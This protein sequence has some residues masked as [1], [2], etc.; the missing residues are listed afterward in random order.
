M[1][2]LP[3]KIRLP[4][5]AYSDRES[6]F[7]VIFHGLPGTTPFRDAEL[8]NAIW[9][10]ITNERERPSIELI[11]ACVMPDHAHFLVSPREKDVVSWVR[12]FKAF[13]SNVGRSISGRRAMWQP[14]FYDRRIRSTDDF[15]TCVEY[16]V[17]NPVAAGLVAELD[18]WP[19]VRSWREA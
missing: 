12:D 11:A 13:S 7:H 10:L 15:E 2:Q 16:I 5:G 17:R 3:K 8:G 19:W 18:N 1:V 6:V 14:S 9:K 4:S